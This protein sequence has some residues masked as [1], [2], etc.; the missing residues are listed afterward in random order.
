MSKL[1]YEELQDEVKKRRTGNGKFQDE[2]GQLRVIIDKLLR[3]I[4]DRANAGSWWND[5]SVCELVRGVECLMSVLSE[6]KK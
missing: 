4:K 6:D 1:W 2:N 5:Q 3:E